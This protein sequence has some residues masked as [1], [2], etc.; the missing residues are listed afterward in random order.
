M[1]LI[2]G[3]RAITRRVVSCALHVL[4]HKEETLAR[5]AELAPLF[6]CAPPQG[7][8]GRGR[9][10]GGQAAVVHGSER[11]LNGAEGPDA[12]CDAKR[13]ASGGAQ[14][15]DGLVSER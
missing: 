1:T 13:S 5:R 12:V 10:G 3:S 14:M 2:I 9:G 6:R 8:R 4:L 7:G 15:G 11:A